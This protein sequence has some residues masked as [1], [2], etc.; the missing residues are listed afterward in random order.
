MKYFALTNDPDHGMTEP[1][2]KIITELSKR[3]IFI[4][5]AVFSTIGQ[6]DSKL[7]EHCN[8]SE[9]DSLENKEYRNLMLKARD[10]GHEIAFHGYSQVSDNRVEFQKG[11]DVYKNVFGDYPKVY[12]EHGGHKKSHPISMVKKE[13]LSHLGREENSEY[14]VEDIV[15]DVFDVVWTHDHLRDDAE[16]PFSFE[17]VFEVKEG[18]TYLNRTRMYHFNKIKK[19]LSEENNIIVGYT[20][21]GYE[22]YKSR[23]NFIRNITDKDSFYERWIG[24]RDLKKVVGLLDRFIKENDIK[25]ITVS[26]LF[27]EYINK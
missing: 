9:T 12:F 16:K 2:D 15:K 20:H 4:T 18:I 23:R 6:D 26:N 1:Y 5:T 27:K 17:N 14:Y 8:A 13:N 24:R 11:L 25:P 3:D 19:G 22:G 21:F 10:L 7:S